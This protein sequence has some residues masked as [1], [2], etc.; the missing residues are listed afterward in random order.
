MPTRILPRALLA[1]GATLV[2][3]ALAYG[4]WVAMDRDGAATGPTVEGGAEGEVP[5]RG[6]EAFVEDAEVGLRP[7]SSAEIRFAQSAIGATVADEIVKHRDANAFLRATP[8][9]ERPEHPRVLL[10]GDSHVDG[11]VSTED[12]VGTLL[13]RSCR[14]NGAPC[15]VLNAACGHYSLWQYVLRATQLVPRW[16]PRAIVVVVFLGNDLLDLDNPT[17]PHLD[18]ELR[19]RPGG[20]L[21]APE[22]T[23]RRYESLALPLAYHHL[24][25][26]GLN[27]AGYIAEQPDRLSVLLAKAGRA[28]DAMQELAEANGATVVWLLLPSFDLVFP[29]CVAALSP[30]AA[31]LV[32]TGA[33]RRVR[34]G[35]AGLLQKRG[36]DWID[37]EPEFRRDGGL[38]LYASDFHVYRRAHRR[39]ADA[40]SARIVPQLSR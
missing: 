3:A 11:A 2:A 22:Q 39:M 9:P 13:E 6:Q 19:E 24:F 31:A 18:D 27:Q 38:D 21:V 37:L 25:W 16:S 8:L 28:V 5:W 10:L 15:H 32:A 36:A 26:Q 12:N 14:A 29:E 34:D 4:V 30:R 40:L 23:T 7:R 35:F 33:Q 1:A 17:M 20:P